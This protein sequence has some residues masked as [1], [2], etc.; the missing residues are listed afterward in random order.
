MHY[1]FY[2]SSSEETHKLASY[3]LKRYLKNCEFLIFLL[4]GELG[5]GKTEFVKGIAKELGFKSFQIKSPSFT[6]IEEFSN[7]KFK[8]FHI[9]LYRIEPKFTN[10]IIFNLI[11]EINFDKK[12]IFC[13]EWAKKLK[14]KVLEIFKNFKK[15]KVLEV[16][17]KIKNYKRKITIKTI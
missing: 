5:S 13:I 14:N 16:N 2:S 10:R 15:S 12:I 7:K 11:E 1:V 6:I 4:N 17:L 8:L 9:D 3:I